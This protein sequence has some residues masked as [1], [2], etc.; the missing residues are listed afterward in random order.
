MNDEELRSAFGTNYK[1]SA[2]PTVKY[3]IFIIYGIIS[4]ANIGDEVF[5]IFSKKHLTNR[6]NVV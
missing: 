6:K 5:L 1:L 4:A 3:L 2:Q